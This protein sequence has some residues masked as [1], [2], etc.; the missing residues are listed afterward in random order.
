MKR[1]P[2]EIGGVTLSLTKS[3]MIQAVKQIMRVLKSINTERKVVA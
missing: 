3:D 1:Y 2:I